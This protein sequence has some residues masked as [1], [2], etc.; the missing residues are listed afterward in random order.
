MNRELDGS[1]S[2][3]AA[4]LSLSPWATL[5]L[6]LA[7]MILTKITFGQEG[8]CLKVSIGSNYAS[9]RVSRIRRSSSSQTRKT[10]CGADQTSGFTATIEPETGAH[11]RVVSYSTSG[12]APQSKVSTTLDTLR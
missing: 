8:R 2:A 1:C 11:P 4:A 12:S 6:R 10:G 7:L 3:A 9:I 5:A